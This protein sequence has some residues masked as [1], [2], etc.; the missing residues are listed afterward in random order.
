MAGLGERIGER[1]DADHALRIGLVNRIYPAEVLLEQSLDY[2]QMLAIRS[3]C[4]LT[5]HFNWSPENSMTSAVPTTLK[6]GLRRS[7]RNAK[8]ALL[9][10][11]RPAARL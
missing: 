1:V 9:A 4:R 5:R 8:L 6:R 7:A 11:N 10:A 2:A 3:A